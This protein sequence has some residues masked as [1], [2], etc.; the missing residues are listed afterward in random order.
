MDLTLAH[1]EKRKKQKGHTEALK[2]RAAELE[3]EQ[4]PRPA[5]KS[6]L[7]AKQ[8]PTTKPPKFSGPCQQ[9]QKGAL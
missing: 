3:G 9:P 5:K 2:R 7:E 4:T 8:A 1:A 6:M